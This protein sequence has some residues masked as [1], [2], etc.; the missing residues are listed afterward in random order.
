MLEIQSLSVCVPGGCPNE[1]K[2]CVS[3]MHESPYQNQIEKNL[4][5]RDLYERDYIRRLQFARD[6]GCNTVILTGDGEPLLNRSFLKDFAHWNNSISSPFRWVEIQTSGVTLD[7]EALR[8][9]RNT[10]GISTISLSLS[11]MYNDDANQ[12]MNGTPDKLKVNVIHLCSEIKRYDFNLRL[13]LNMT[14][15][16]QKRFKILTNAGVCSNLLDRARQLGADQVTFRRLYVS[17]NPHLE[18][19][20]WIA[21]HAANDNLM[22]AINQYVREN[23]RALEQLPFGAIRYSLNGLSVV[24]DTDCMNVDVKP[25]MKYL[26][27]RPNCKL[28]TK[29]D[30]PGSLLF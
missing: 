18:Q 15:T 7:D 21:E 20:R 28:Y 25:V 3:K 11:D 24:T 13:S 4:R 30:D 12:E 9:L 10:V 23:G 27:L 5:F 8:F 14:D 29:W 2:F 1:C 17:G 19:N 16:Y 26:V 6:N 22:V